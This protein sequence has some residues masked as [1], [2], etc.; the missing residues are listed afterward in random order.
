MDDISSTNQVIISTHSPLLVNRGEI[1]RNLIVNKSNATSAKNIAEIRDI[2]GVKIADNLRSA[3]LII[4]TEGEDDSI[5]LKS[6]ISQLSNSVK[7][8]ID[9]GDISFDNLAGANNLAYKVSLWK[10]LLCDVRAFL[11]NDDTGN[12]G[13]AEASSKGLITL[14][15][16]T[17]STVTNY[18]ESEIEDLV[19][20]DTYKNEIMIKYGVNLE[21]SP[22]FRNSK[23][24]W[25]LRMQ[26][27][28]KK[29]GKIWNDNIKAEAKRVVTQNASSVGL[30][31]LNKHHRKPVK[32]FV[33]SL[34]EY[35]ASKANQ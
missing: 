18:K 19:D 1:T 22:E 28:F 32:L 11:D 27:A 24:K 14:H 26:E 2:L 8:A 6:W 20:L 35:F 16:V 10:S 34:E 31:S 13:F 33:V 3:N 7:S 23:R 17:F 30:S 12:T 21:K 29:G 4:L 15:D 25:S 9:N 5:L